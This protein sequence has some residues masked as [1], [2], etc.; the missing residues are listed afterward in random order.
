MESTHSDNPSVYDQSDPDRKRKR[1]VS[2]DE[3][4]IGASLPGGHRCIRSGSLP[5]VVYRDPKENGRLIC[6]LSGVSRPALPRLSSLP[7]S[8][9]QTQR[10]DGQ[11]RKSQASGLGNFP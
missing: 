11:S 6:R 1:S 2:V 3:S 5:T 8:A 9:H 4:A 10:T 7:K